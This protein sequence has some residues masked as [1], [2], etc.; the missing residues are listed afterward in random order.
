MN[1]IATFA[2][3]Q[4]SL[5]NTLE[6]QRQL[7]ESQIQVSSGK[8]APNYLGVAT[9]S[10]R[11]VNLEGTLTATEGYNK[12]IDLIE[13]RLATMEANVGAAFDLASD[14]RELLVSATSGGNASELGLNQ[15]AADLIETLG[16]LVNVKQDDRY[17]FAGSRVDT[18][19]IDLSSL[20]AATPPLVAAAEFT[21]AATTSTTGIN[22]LTGI[23]GVQVETGNTGDAFPTDLQ[24][25]HPDV[26]HDQPEWRHLFAGR[27][28]WCPLAR[29]DE[30]FD[31]H[32]GRRARGSDHR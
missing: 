15:K 6:T 28:G 12:N 18:L 29:H 17:L 31:L 11:L 19:P 20:L 2:I 30:G 24:R 8:V 23:V 3:Q 5:S 21:G 10:R 32:G 27:P 13:R 16:G 26:L 25:R 14:F 9:E 7:Y 22:S 4:L 1:R